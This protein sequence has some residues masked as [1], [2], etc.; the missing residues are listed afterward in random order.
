MLPQQEATEFINVVEQNVDIL[1]NAFQGVYPGMTERGMKR[2]K[3]DTIS[4]GVFRGSRQTQFETRKFSR[5]IG[6]HP[7]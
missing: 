3:T 4:V 5:P 1:E 2:L 7:A 6:E